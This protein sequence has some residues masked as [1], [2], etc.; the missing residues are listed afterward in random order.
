MHQ[1]ISLSCCLEKHAQPRWESSIIFAWCRILRTRLLTLCSIRS[2][3]P[4]K[5]KWFPLQKLCQVNLWS[6]WKEKK[7]KK[8][9]TIPIM[10]IKFRC[11]SADVKCGLVTVSVCS[12]QNIWRHWDRFEGFSSFLFF[13]LVY[14]LISLHCTYDNRKKKIH[15]GILWIFLKATICQICVSL[16]HLL[17]SVR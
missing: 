8:R 3:V 6:V 16:Q 17:R 1:F 14:S 11:V 12:C 10:P 5:S 13:V 7:R 9:S 4:W 15:P 2:I